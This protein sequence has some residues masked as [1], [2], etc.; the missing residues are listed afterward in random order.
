VRRDLQGRS[1]YQLTQVYV[2]E[3]KAR[4]EIASITARNQ[5]TMLARLADALPAN[6]TRIKR[7]H[8][9]AWLERPDISNSY[10]RLMLTSAK[11][12]SAWL[13]R[14]NVLTQDPTDQ[15]PVPR[16]PRRLPRGLPTADVGKILAACTDPRT[17]LMIVLMA[18]EGLRR[19]EVAGLQWGD[20][21]FQQGTM[22]IIGKGGHERVLPISDETR[23]AI[24]DYLPERGHTGGPLFYNRDHPPRPISPPHVGTLVGRVIVAAGLKSYPFDGRSGHALRHTAASD[25]LRAGAHLRDVQAALGHA[26]ITTTQRYLPFLVGDLRT[27][28]GGRK[29]RGAHLQAVD[30][31][32]RNEGAGA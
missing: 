3:R 23:R 26:S 7:R 9:E 17:R 20:I 16:E 27:A 1:S 22:F 21:D 28:M 2:A 25:M 8:L 4:G 18:Q 11:G 15:I 14:E 5:F 32:A 6:P 30:P 12:F 13:I 29:Y 31:P 24:S 19:V 10:R